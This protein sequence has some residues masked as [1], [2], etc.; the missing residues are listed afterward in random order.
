[1]WIAL[2]SLALGQGAPATSFRFGGQFRLNTFAERSLDEGSVKLLGER[3]RLRPTAWVVLDDRVE[4]MLQ[5][6][7]N[8]VDNSFAFRARYADAAVRFDDT[9]VHVGLLPLSDKFG[10]T[11]FSADWDFNPLAILVENH[12][13]DEGAWRGRLAAGLIFQGPI[14]VQ[15]VDDVRIVL[16][17]LDRGMLGFSGVVVSTGPDAAVIPGTLLSIAGVRLAPKLGESTLN[18]G[19][20]GSGLFVAGDDPIDGPSRGAFSPES[21]GA[22]VRAEFT[23]PVGAAKLSVLGL[24]ATGG[25]LDGSGI[26]HAFQTPMSQFGFHGYWGYTA[27]LTVQGPTDQGMDDPYNIDGGT[28]DK[29]NLGRGMSTLQA[30]L[31]VPFGEHV[32]VVGAAGG[33][34]AAEGGLYGID[35]M[36][37]F[38]WS[39]HKAVSL[40]TIG[41]I[42]TFGDAHHARARTTAVALAVRLQLEF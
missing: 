6:E 20:L 12:A 10:D 40:D 39:P 2:T 41:T 25:G 11:L 22:A 23:A 34:G 19:F 26:D 29:T 33:F 38:V 32:R 8:Q 1:M 7:A 30:K 36:G 28:Y 31:A 15:A 3:L 17:D 27:R 16:G 18:L 5:L 37:E 24:Y 35:G 9:R 4:G 14:T 42:T 21:L 13:A